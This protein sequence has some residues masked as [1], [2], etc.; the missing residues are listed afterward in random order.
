MVP[1]INESNAEE[2]EEFIINNENDEEGQQE[3]DGDEVFNLNN[4]HTALQ[5][6]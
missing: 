6:R 5:L 4:L 3:E 2:A 1:G